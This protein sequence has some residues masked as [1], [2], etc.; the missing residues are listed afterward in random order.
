MTIEHL[1]PDEPGEDVRRT[2]RALYAPPSAPS[3]WDGLERRIMERVT[4]GGPVEWWSFF[5]GWKRAGLIAA[6]IAA[7]LT[8]VVALR[9]REVDARLA[10]EAVIE[11]P[12][13][14][15]NAVAN[16]P[17]I[18]YGTSARDVTLRYL[19]TR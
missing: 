19:L 17:V 2:M 9:S 16:A 10:Y 8:A 12:D 3:Y 4:R 14:A 5:D 6:G 13:S 7:I 11:A 1:T 15:L 18:P